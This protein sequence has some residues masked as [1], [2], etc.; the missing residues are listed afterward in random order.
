[1][2]SQWGAN[3]PLVLPYDSCSPQDL[4]TATMATKTSDCGT[5]GAMREPSAATFL[6]LQALARRP[7][8]QV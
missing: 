7:S 4:I 5:F 1:M 2:M 8:E 6:H 3:R